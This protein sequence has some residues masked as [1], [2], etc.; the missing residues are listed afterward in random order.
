MQVNHKLMKKVLLSIIIPVVF[1]VL[2]A[3]S[4]RVTWDS[5]ETIDYGT[6]R[7]TYPKS[8]AIGI[9]FEGNNSVISYSGRSNGQKFQISNL[10]WEKVTDKEL[11]D[12]NRLQLPEIEEKGISYFF[13]HNE[14]T[15][16][17]NVRISGFKF[18]HGT[19]YR[20]SSFSLTS[21]GA[22]AK[23]SAP[24]SKFGTMDNPLKSGTFY[25]IKVDTTGIFK[26]TSKF[27][28]DNGINPANVNPQ[29]FRIYGNGGIPLPEFNQ[30]FKYNALQENAIQV[31]GESDGVWN[32]DD[33]A[34]FYAQ[35]PNVFNVYRN[36]V[37]N[38]N[39][40]TDTRGDRSMHLKNIYEDHAYYFINFDLGPG[41]R[42]MDEDLSVPSTLISRFDDYQ[43]VDTDKTNLLKIG[44]VWVA[45]PFTSSKSVTFKTRSA[46]KPQDIIHYRTSVVG[47]RAQN[48]S[49]AY[50]ING[51]NQ[52]T[53]NLP[54]DAQL[55]IKLT[56]FSGTAS[57]LSGNTLTLNF[58]P[59]I[60]ANPNGLFYLDYAEVLYKEDLIFNGQQM[61]FRSYDITEN[62]AALYGFSMSSASMAEQIW[63]VSDITNAK[64]KINKSGNNSVFNFGYNANSPY[65]SNEFVAFKNTA[66]YEPT[67]VGRIDNQ[68]L[69][70]LNNIDYLIITSREMMAD[71]ERLANHHKNKNGFN[72]AVVDVEKVYNEFSSGSK[73]ITAIRDFV[74]RLHTQTGN[75]KYVLLIGDSSYDYK[76]LTTNNDNIII[77]YQSENS[78]GFDSSFVT[79]DYFVMTKPQTSA[80][81]FQNLPD[82]PIGRLPA[83]NTSEAKLLVD[84]TLAYYNGLPGQSTPFG[85]WRMRL[86]F[87]VDDDFDGGIPFHNEMNSA[88]VSGFETTAERQEYNVKKDYLDSFAPEAS[89]GGQRY[90]QVNQLIS[91]A[92]GNSL[93]LFYFG[94]GGIN[95]WAQERVLTLD[96][97]QAFNNFTPVYSRFPMVSTITCEFTLWDEP[98]VQSAGEQVLKHKTGGAATMITSSR[99]IGVPYGRSFTKLF[100]EEIFRLYN[101]DFISLGEAHLKAKIRKGFDSNHFKVNY[102]GDPAMKLSRPKQQLTID[103]IESPVKDQLRA[104]D[105]VKITGRVLQDDGTVDTAFNGRVAINIF[106]KKL[107]KTTLNNDKVAG[108]NPV[109]KYVEEGSAI[110]KSSGKAVNGNYTV[111]FYVP[112]DI[113]YELGSGRIL[114]YADNFETAKSEAVDVYTNQ[115]VQIGGINEN[116][117]NDDT[118]PKVHLF[119]N[120]T[121]FADGGITDQNPM[122]LACITDD[123][124]INSAGSGIGHDI[125]VYLDGEIV[126]TVI[127]NDFFTSGDGNGCTN[128]SLADYQKGSVTYPFRNL[129]PGPHQLTFKVWDINNNSTTATLNFTVKDEAEQKLV[130]NKLL[131][132]PNPFTD[133]T[134]VHFEHNCDDIL[135]V[136][137]QIYTITGRL[138]RTLS[139]PVSSEP[140]MEGF[141]TPRQAIEWDGRDDFGSTVGKGTYIYKVLVRSQ[142]QDKCK[143]SATAVEK[144]VVLK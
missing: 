30:D 12:L 72:T 64:R 2:S 62:S 45:D 93:Y 94:H 43:F 135:D 111:E 69:Y 5:S 142:N 127:L 121:S 54:N 50:N 106:D 65:F 117:L 119:M 66:A 85:E 56:T 129:K 41:K 126:N 18:D 63:D 33:Y 87:V 76:D 48:N 17:Y 100:T 15:E 23:T 6:Y 97:I 86:D 116:G 67:F 42:V 36:N 51:Q 84:K 110:V 19:V 1:S 105:F 39:R 137:V 27:L 74:T 70:G 34:L 101:N 4:I 53:Y 47:F 133:K 44:R 102:L 22:T 107:N 143:G 115:P 68:D 79:D 104:L 131:N 35:G 132:W 112:K 40:R 58:S 83:S 49:I 108:L 38:E 55:Y 77:S 90:P 13:D 136:N 61:N 52:T 71:A 123:T 32:E 122:L 28:A 120:N 134:Y 95:G 29:N 73:D 96:E 37:V 124:G 14:N 25:K 20:L 24:T 60:T 57:N 130:I 80:S 125:T 75:L 91:S 99:A 9:S 21:S 81:I 31:V 141:R 92:A 103:N 113:N 128:A 139:V 8:S 82:L 88:L 144:M 3:Q 114:A 59:T 138:V 46:I 26:I 7:K 98:E 118:P 78:S 140:F 109:L 89:A 11:F 10:N 16:Y